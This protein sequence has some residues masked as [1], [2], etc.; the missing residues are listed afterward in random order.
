MSK[1]FVKERV[2]KYLMGF[3]STSRYD[4]HKCSSK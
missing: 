4:R 2:L 3:T 1:E